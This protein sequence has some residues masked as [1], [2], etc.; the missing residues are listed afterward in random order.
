MKPLILVV[1]DNEDIL[2]NLK[3]SLEKYDY[4]VITAISGNDALATLNKLETPPNLIISDI[5]MAEMNGF[6]FFERVSSNAKLY[7]VPFIFL[8]AKS[9]LN[10][11]RFGKSLG[12]DDYLT[13]PINERDLIASISG[14]ITR[15][16]KQKAINRKIS[17]LLET[18]DIN[19]ESTISR[20]ELSHF[21]LLLMC[22]DDVYGP[23]LKKS[24]SNHKKIPY[25]IEKTGIQLFNAAI[26]IYGQDNI[27]KGEG[28]LLKLENIKMQAY[29]Y[30]N[31]YNDEGTRS[32]QVQYMLTVIAPE[33]N[34][35]RSLQIKEVLQEISLNINE[36]QKWDI[37]KYAKKILQQLTST[38]I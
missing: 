20:E 23:K 18:Y 17:Q 30:F 14:K 32:G 5:M 28:I 9:S 1:D 16:Q 29:V 11:I 34:Y 3:L 22:W 6:D 7:E 15:T 4:R 24:Y 35:F 36:K 10:D 37:K 25:D 12:V 2:F 21:T 13:K 26:F 31:A 8:T 38:L 19:L 33:I 27:F